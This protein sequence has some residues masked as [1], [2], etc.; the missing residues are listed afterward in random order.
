MSHLSSGKVNLA[1]VREAG[2]RDLLNCIDRCPGSKAVVWDEKLTGPVGLVAEYSLLK[3]HEVGKMFPLSRGKLPHC[4]EQNIIFL[5]RPKIELME[6]I[7]GNI[8]LEESKGSSKEY[9]IFFVPRKSL[10]CEQKLQ[11]WMLIKITVYLASLKKLAR[12]FWFSW[13][14]I[15]QFGPEKFW[16][17]WGTEGEGEVA[18]DCRNGGDLIE[19]M[20]RCHEDQVVGP[21]RD[22]NPLR[23]TI[24][25]AMSE[26]YTTAPQHLQK[27]PCAKISG[28]FPSAQN[29]LID[30]FLH[31]FSD[32]FATVPSQFSKKA[33]KFCLSPEWSGST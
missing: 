30:Q 15:S 5:V 29:S 2:R 22:S 7:A 25:A 21:Y 6:I 31:R 1:Q 24:L 20:T 8:K 9:H 27:F 10:L 4:E 11:V 18:F 12:N 16:P 19:S 32:Q 13:F 23:L 3:E 28:S 14:Q 26:D 17:A 33:C